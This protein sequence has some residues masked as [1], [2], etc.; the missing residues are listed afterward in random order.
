MPEQ[1][2]AEKK[3]QQE[4]EAAEKARIEEHTKAEKG[5]WVTV[6]KGNEELQINRSTLSA[7]QDA[8]WKLVQGE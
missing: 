8:G 6:K 4:A 3:A 7:H 5:N 1:T 2:A